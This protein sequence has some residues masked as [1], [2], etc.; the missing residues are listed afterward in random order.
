MASSVT[1]PAQDGYQPAIS[2]NGFLRERMMATPKV[3]LELKTVGTI[4][5]LF[6]L[7]LVRLIVRA[8][9]QRQP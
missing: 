1:L 4:T 2:D 3:L 5:V 9:K 6:S 7:L 8:V